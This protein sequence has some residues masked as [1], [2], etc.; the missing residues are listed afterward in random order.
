[1]AEQNIKLTENGLYYIN[2]KR[3]LYYQDGVWYHPVFIS[4]R[5]TGN[6][7]DLDRQPK[8]IKTLDKINYR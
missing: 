4:G 2:G 8:R 5:Y 1:M 3:Q 7:R 6:I